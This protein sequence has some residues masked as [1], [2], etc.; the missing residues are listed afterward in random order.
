[1]TYHHVIS[2]RAH[3]QHILDLEDEYVYNIKVKRSEPNGTNMTYCWHYIIA[4]H[5]KKLRHDGIE[6][7]FD[8]KSS[9]HVSSC[10]AK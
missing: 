7:L 6:I 8:F 10:S 4:E 9:R 5:I 1:V 3:F 2:Y